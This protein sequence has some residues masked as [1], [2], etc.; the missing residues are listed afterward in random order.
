MKFSMSS[1]LFL[2]S[3][4]AGLDC[5]TQGSEHES[6][7][8]LA[9]ERDPAAT[10]TAPAATPT[11]PAKT[12]ADIIARY[13][14][15]TVLTKQIGYLTTTDYEYLPQDF[16]L[17]D[18]K[19]QLVRWPRDGVALLTDIA[20]RENA[21]AIA[22]S[23]ALASPAWSPLSTVVSQPEEWTALSDRYPFMRS[24]INSIQK[25]GIPLHYWFENENTP[26]PTVQKQLAKLS[27]HTQFV[28][29]EVARNESN[30][31]TIIGST[32]GNWSL[33]SVQTYLDSP[34]FKSRGP[35]YQNRVRTRL[36]EADNQ[37]RAMLTY[38]SSF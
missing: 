35:V 14:P 17:P 9:A 23:S 18:F 4:A 31:K 16:M 11:A 26:I 15:S 20:S 36:R 19:D 25:L 33:T 27:R 8:Q 34:E 13:G 22:A 12:W 37:I 7:E 10:P 3:V 6:I 21:I 1:I 29:R 24:A 5:G 28:L 30:L 38:I 32:G 2:I